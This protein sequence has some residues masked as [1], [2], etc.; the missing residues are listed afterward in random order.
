MSSNIG[1]TRDIS[2]SF[3]HS[4]DSGYIVIVTG[5]FDCHSGLTPSPE[6]PV[7]K[8]QLA[9]RR[10]ASFSILEHCRHK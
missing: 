9:L 8:R 4:D 3:I 5:V 7:P 10:A 6:Y 1:M 2:V